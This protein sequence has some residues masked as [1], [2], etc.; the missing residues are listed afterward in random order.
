MPLHLNLMDREVP[1]EG[2]RI[3]A[4]VPLRRRGGAN[5]R[6][7]AGVQLSERGNDLSARESA[8]APAACARP[9][10]AAPAGALGFRSGAEFHLAAS[11]PA[12]PQALSHHDFYFT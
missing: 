6:L 5:R 2:S 11:E 8:A 10:Q 7:V 3:S 9:Y 1:N 4:G 12:H